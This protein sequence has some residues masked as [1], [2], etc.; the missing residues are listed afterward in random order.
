MTKPL[1]VTEVALLFG[2]SSKSV[3]RW[4]NDGRLPYSTTLGGHR[5]FDPERIAAIAAGQ[6][7]EVDEPEAQAS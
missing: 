3:V 5:R 6:H 7:F 1:K 2:V 4:C